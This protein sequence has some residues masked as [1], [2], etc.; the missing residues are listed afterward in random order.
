[1]LGILSWSALNVMRVIGKAGIAE[2][3]GGV[4]ATA[5]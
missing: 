4:G 5:S 3:M 2:A 1:M